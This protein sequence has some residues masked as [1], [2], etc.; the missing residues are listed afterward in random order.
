MIAPSMKR[1]HFTIV[2]L[3][4]ATAACRTPRDARERHHPEVRKAADTGQASPLK[5]Y[6]DDC[7][8]R[9]EQAWQEEVDRRGGA[10]DDRA[11][12]QKPLLATFT[13]LADGSIEDVH[14]HEGV[15]P[16]ARTLEMIDATFKNIRLP[17]MPAEVAEANGG[18]MVCG[19]WLQMREG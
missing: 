17:P 5:R 4:L 15:S 14:F 16:S 2:A 11:L 6:N 12:L 9:I 3:A 1:A 18:R 13:V 7:L 19:I 8:H 10:T